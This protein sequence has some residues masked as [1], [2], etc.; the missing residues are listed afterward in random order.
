MQNRTIADSILL[1]FFSATV[2]NK[3]TRSLYRREKTLMSTVQACC[4]TPETL[5]LKDALTV[6]T[7]DFFN[8]MKD[9][10]KN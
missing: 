10:N 2:F 5:F 4:D 7:L 8:P 1:P 3:H 9:Q 6:V